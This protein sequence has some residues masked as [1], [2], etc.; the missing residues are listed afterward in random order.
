MV[1]DDR[2]AD[3]GSFDVQVAMYV[4]AATAGTALVTFVAALLA[5]PISG[6]N[7]RNECIEYPYLDTT[8]RYP[9]DYVWMYL[10]IGLIVAYLLLV[11]TVR[12]LGPPNRRLLG[13]MAVALAG[14]SAAVLVP[15]Y[16][17]QASVVPAS[18]AAGETDGIALLTQYN[19]HG[20]FIALEE[21][22]Y[23]TMNGSFLLLA[24]LVRNTGRRSSAIRLLFVA[25]FVVTSVALAAYSVA[26][27]LDRQDRFEVI[28]LT[29]AWFTLLVSGILLTLEYK[30]RRTQSARPS[31][32]SKR[33]DGASIDV[34][35]EYADPH[36]L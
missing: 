25:A 16:F 12:H 34:S 14:V 22:G 36:K 5:V 18:L 24:P 29:V 7:C 2:H 27:G 33:H 9:R 10:A 6:A 31:E 13:N 23:L 1:G 17:V 19:P 30:H 8:D 21:I 3:G 26:H 15:A 32:T 20:V 11:V 35:G 28:A 4:S